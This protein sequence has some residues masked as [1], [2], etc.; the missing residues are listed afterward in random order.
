MKESGEH[1]V[2]V[3]EGLKAERVRQARLLVSW[4]NSVIDALVR[5]G[6]KKL[7]APSPT[8][9]NVDKVY[10]DFLRAVVEEIWQIPRRLNNALDAGCSDAMRSAGTDFFYNLQ[11]VAPTLE[12]KALD[13]KVSSELKKD[14][15]QK[16]VD[17]VDLL[18]ALRP[19]VP[20]A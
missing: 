4:S 11:Q 7:P 1:L 6:G 15:P 18:V 13:A 12:F 19:G 9:A 5:T 20:K 8:E 10:I 14:L 3:K 16:I 17:A 2:A